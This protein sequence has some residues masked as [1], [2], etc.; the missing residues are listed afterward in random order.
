VSQRSQTNDRYRKDAELGS[1]R[2]S[3]ASAKP[4]R[5]AATIEVGSGKDSGKKKGK[6]AKGIKGVKGS[7]ATKPKAASLQLPTSPEI[8]KW[9]TVWWALLGGAFVLLAIAWLVPALRTNPTANTVATIGVF[10]LC[11]AGLY[12]DL[13]IIRKLRNKLIE[14]QKHKKPSKTVAKAV[15]AAE[16]AKTA[17]VAKPE[18]P[19]IKESSSPLGGLF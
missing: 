14:E 17:E 16:P 1:T 12:I 18:T 11:S 8:K 15:K 4:V 2:K 19:I 3:A 13:V 9:R 5:K 10:V 7:K 6:D